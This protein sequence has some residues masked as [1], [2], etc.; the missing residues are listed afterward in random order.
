MP[1]NMFSNTF[2]TLS[3]EV[4]E[5]AQTL[6]LVNSIVVFVVCF[7]TLL[8]MAPPVLNHL[9]TQDIFLCPLV[10]EYTLGPYVDPRKVNN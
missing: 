8:E 1:F 5:Y 7:S 4:I 9:W 3:H 2:N 10:S 6:I